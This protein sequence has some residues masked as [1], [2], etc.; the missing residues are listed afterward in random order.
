VQLSPEDTPTDLVAI[1]AAIPPGAVEHLEDL[2][3]VRL[4]RSWRAYPAPGALAD[5]GAAW[6]RAGRRPALSVPSAVIPAERNYLIDPRHRLFSQVR[7][8]QPQAFRLDPRMW[9]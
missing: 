9:K 7:L 6:I 3:G 8:E 5:V 2:P 1:A 4:P